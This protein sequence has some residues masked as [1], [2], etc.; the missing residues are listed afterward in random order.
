[1]VNAKSEESLSLYLGSF[2]LQMIY[3]ALQTITYKRYYKIQNN[4]AA[5]RRKPCQYSLLARLKVNE[6]KK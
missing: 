5:A 2:F 3:T 6:K 1:M 4:T